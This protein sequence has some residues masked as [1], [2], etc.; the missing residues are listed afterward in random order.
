MEFCGL[1][2]GYYPSNRPFVQDCDDSRIAEECH[3]HLYDIEKDIGILWHPLLMKMTATLCGSCKRQNCCCT[4][5]SNS[6]YSFLYLS[7]LHNNYN[8]VSSKSS[9]S[10]L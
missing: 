3:I 10:H 5:V 7:C 6:A 2:K 9:F 4:R 8:S 1:N